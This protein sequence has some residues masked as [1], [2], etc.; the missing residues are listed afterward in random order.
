MAAFQ[1]VRR[2]FESGH[3]LLIYI[4][5]M[6]QD[7]CLFEIN[8]AINENVCN[9]IIEESKNFKMIPGK[10]AD[11][12]TPNNKIRQSKIFWLPDDSWIAGM[13][14]HFIQYANKHYYHYDLADVW[15]DHIQ[16]TEY[17]ETDHYSWHKDFRA[18]SIDRSLVR[19]LSISLVLSS[20]D[21]YEGGELQ[22]MDEVYSMKTVKPARGS[23]LIFPSYTPHR[24]RKVKSG[25]RIS[26]VGWYAGPRFK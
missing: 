23:I 13:M 19:K 17:D 26:L 10:I 21:E 7:K 6:N 20:P 3:P 25:K 22:V 1:A 11:S 2:P 12:K 9:C 14:A 18:S 16:Y 15:A 8:A 24:V 4:I 5:S